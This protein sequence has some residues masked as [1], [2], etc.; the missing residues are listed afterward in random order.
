[1]LLV[2]VATENERKPLKQFLAAF[3]GVEVF[4]T[5]MGPVTTA[6]SLSS[7]LALHG[8]RIDGVLNIGVAGAYIDSGLAM[9]DIC[10]A[11]QE[12]LGDFGICMQD[13]I[14]YFD[15][16]LHKPGAALLFNNDLVRQFKAQ[17]THHKIAF[18]GA[19]FVTVNCCSGTGE[20]GEF[21]RK[22]FA[23]GCENMEGAAVIM[24]CKNFNIPCAELRCI[25]NMVEDRDTENWKLTEAI[26]KICM[27]AEIVAREYVQ[28]ASSHV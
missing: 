21:F 6:A 12:F 16:G 13:E 14:K 8:S 10:L 9:L 1:M 25:S 3:E 23:A 20:R 4:V 26:E 19:N 24:V 28:S 17:L 11:Q 7:Y 15:P 22:K 27:V 2:V 5:G 18:S